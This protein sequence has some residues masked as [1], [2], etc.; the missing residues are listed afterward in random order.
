MRYDIN[1]YAYIE[2]PRSNK[3]LVLTLLAVLVAVGAVIAVH[4]FQQPV[5]PALSTPVIDN[6]PVVNEPFEPL[7]P[8]KPSA[9]P[10]E[11][12]CVQ[13]NYQRLPNE[14]VARRADSAY[15]VSHFCEAEG[16]LQEARRRGHP[17]S[18]CGMDLFWQE[19]GR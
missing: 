17:W 5:G 18:C 3:P 12:T 10:H 7:E 2:K 9:A 6:T 16:L 13:V 19:Q 15:A 14:E 4:E 1:D 11:S 8:I